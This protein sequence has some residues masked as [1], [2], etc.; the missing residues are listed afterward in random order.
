MG[1]VDGQPTAGMKVGP[2]H[3]MTKIAGM[4]LVFAAS[5]FL[6]AGT[7][8]WPAAWIFLAL[9]FGFTSALSLWLFRCSPDLLAERFTGI[10]KPDQPS[11][12][13]VLLSIT[14]VAFFAW[15]TVMGFD[16]VRRG[17]SHMPWWLQG[18]GACLLLA[19][20]AVFFATFR[21]HVW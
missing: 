2:V 14:A 3:L 21:E 4:A 11:W 9:F 8:A 18:V 6:S 5:L 7:L 20:F 17:W 10:G 19:S 1:S 12:D 16:T 15:L 13:K